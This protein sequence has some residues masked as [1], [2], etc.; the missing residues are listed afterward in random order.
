MSQT[1]HNSSHAPSIRQFARH[2][3][4]MVMAMFAG[5]LVLGLPAELILRLFGTSTSELQ[6]T[7][8]AV[9]LFGMGT[10]MTIPMVAWMRYR[11]HGW[12]PSMEMAAS[13][14]VPTFAV[15]ALLASGVSDF[16]AALVIEHVAMFPSMLAVMLLRWDEY[17]MPHAH[18]PALAQASA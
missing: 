9:V 7:A 6:I 4:E 12:Q 5:M 16:D 8:P 14:F 2:Y 1:S 3:G 11:G 13:M 15:I 18:H 17:A 10:V